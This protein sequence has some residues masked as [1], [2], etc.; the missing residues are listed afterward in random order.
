VSIDKERWDALDRRAQD[1]YGSTNS[2]RLLAF[3]QQVVAA[4]AD[5]RALVRHLAEAEEAIRDLQHQLRDATILFAGAVASQPDR[6]L[7]VQHRA[8][9]TDLTLERDD[10]PVADEIVFRIVP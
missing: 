1:I 2:D 3:C 5:G 9:K 10:N 7:R 4:C 8:M 6:T